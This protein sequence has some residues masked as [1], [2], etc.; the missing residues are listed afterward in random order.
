MTARET[1][2]IYDDLMRFR[3][4]ELTPNAW[5]VKA[6]VSR[7]VWAD[8]RRHGNPSRRTLEKLLVAA[9]SSLAEFEALR[10]SGRD[11]RQEK[12]GS[13][14]GD[15]STEGWAGPQLAPLP[16]V[17]TASAGEWGEPPS[18]I[19]MTELRLDEVLERIP[20]PV[21][22]ANDA[23]AYA[24]TIVGNSMWPRFRAGRRIAVSPKGEVAIGDDILVKLKGETPGSDVRGIATALI[25]ELVR[26]DRSGLDLR[27][28]N[29]DVVFRVPRAAILSIEKVLGELV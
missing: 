23:D 1:T 8:M 28:F 24:V 10:V 19:D 5:A 9:G 26:S 13:A 2:G 27:Q 4:H 7:T 11:S 12:A 14:V 3:P 20:R 22:L 18:R 6:G 21:A 15:R 25:K 17:R 29:P 16:L